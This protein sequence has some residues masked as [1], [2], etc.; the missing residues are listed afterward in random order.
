MPIKTLTEQISTLLAANDVWSWLF[1]AVVVA[2][3]TALLK[4]LLK[5]L[6]IRLRKLAKHTPSIWAGVMVDLIDGLKPLV[7]YFW[8]F[9]HAI[10]PLNPTA[11]SQKFILVAVVIFSIFQV[12]LWG[13]HVIRSWKNTVL[14]KKIKEDPSSEA[15]LSLLYKAIQTIFLTIVVL[16]GLSNLGIDIGALLAGLGVGGVAVALAA[17]NIL[18]D[19]LA[20]LSIVLDKPF[21]I[22][23]FIVAGE[24]K[25]TI[26]S[27]GIKTTRVRSLSGEEIVLSNK[28]LLESRI[29]NY[30]QM[31]LRRIEQKFGVVYNTPIETLALIPT[32]VKSAVEKHDKLK[33]DR[34]HF[35]AYGNSSLDFELIFFVLDR[36][37][38][39]YMDYQQKVLLDIFKK[40]SDEGVEFAFPT[41][42]L[43]VKKT[44][45]LS[46]RISS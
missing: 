13:H 38:N 1:I 37:Y 19:L 23:D 6:S 42:T 30:K 5:I 31:W 2:I 44:P 17:Q 33:F 7:L 32:W 36:D 16:I 34:C 14:H 21:V 35:A 39:V 12:A 25:G 15:A 20:S 40:F 41:Q 10:K 3:V 27:I 18:G 9:Y 45:E 29:H 11:F 4:L 28:D 8:V 43:Y 22:G 24:E 46:E 26:E